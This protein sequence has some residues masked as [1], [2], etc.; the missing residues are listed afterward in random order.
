MPLLTIC[1][2]QSH[3]PPATELDNLDHGGPMRFRLCVYSDV[4]S[5]NKERG[6]RHPWVAGANLGL[7][8][9]EKY[10]PLTPGHDTEHPDSNEH[11]SVIPSSTY[12]LT[13]TAAAST[14]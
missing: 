2:G 3:V 13:S 11:M 7:W 9:A 14:Q 1:P 12:R 8:Q 4:Y 10:C 5:Y 6:R